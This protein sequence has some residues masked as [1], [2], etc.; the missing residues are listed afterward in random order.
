MRKISDCSPFSKRSCS[1][2]FSVGD[3]HACA[4]MD[5]ATVQ[6]WGLDFAGALGPRNEAIE[7]T[8]PAPVGTDS[9]YAGSFA[10]ALRARLHEWP[11]AFGF[12]LAFNGPI[13]FAAFAICFACATG[14]AP[15]SGRRS[16]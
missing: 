5:D 3:T 6:C 4:T 10:D 15:F 16:E 7:D 2:R 8:L 14:L 9:G 13:A 12:V 1:A 11:F